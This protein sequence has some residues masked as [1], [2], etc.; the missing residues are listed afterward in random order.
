MSRLGERAD[1]HKAKEAKT[2]GGPNSKGILC[3]T[4]QVSSRLLCWSPPPQKKAGQQF[5]LVRKGGGQRGGKMGDPEAKAVRRGEPQALLGQGG[6]GAGPP[7]VFWK[8]ND[9]LGLIWVQ[10]I[11]GSVH[12]W[13][14]FALSVSLVEGEQHSAAE[15]DRVLVQEGGTG[16]AAFIQ[17]MGKIHVTE[18]YHE[19]SV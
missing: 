17:W 14:N 12:V 5:L 1:E 19:G 16:R 4:G 7:K 6:D 18:T 3:E 15:E 9:A 2:K 13:D 8:K 11:T 10:V